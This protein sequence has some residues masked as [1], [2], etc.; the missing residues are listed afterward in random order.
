MPSRIS[1]ARLTPATP[2][3]L[4]SLAAAPE[5][6]MGPLQRLSGSTSRSNTN[7]FMMH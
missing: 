6:A 1:A 4:E 2:A 5:P 3:V 7:C